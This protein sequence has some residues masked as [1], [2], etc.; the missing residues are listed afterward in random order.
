MLIEQLHALPG[1]LIRRAHQVSGAVFAANLADYDLTSVQYAAMV[2]IHCNPG[3]D[4]TRLANLTASDKATIGG[5]IDR[6]EVKSLVRRGP[7]K[8][9]RRIKAVTL[10]AA[11]KVLL[12]DV[13]Q[14][15]LKA[16]A[17]ML[18][19]LS[20]SEQRLFIELLKKLVGLPAQAVCR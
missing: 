18:D 13:E 14:Q 2:A 9:D 16:Q 4:A 1:H 15:V 3:I 19:P 8:G 7:S 5:V 12:A 6:L 10:T 11:G 17:D 20:E